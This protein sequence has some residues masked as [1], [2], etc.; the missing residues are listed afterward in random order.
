VLTKKLDAA[1]ISYTVNTDVDEMVALGI[2]SA[3][4]LDVNGTLMDFSSANTWLR[5]QTAG[6]E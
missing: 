4:M 6:K 1:G 3:P 5:E 2:K